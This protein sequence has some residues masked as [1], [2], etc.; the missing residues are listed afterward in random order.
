MS[1]QE[2]VIIIGGG[3]AGISSALSLAE[4][5]YQAYIIEKKGSIGGHAMQFCCKATKQCNNCGVCLVKDKI[6]KVVSHPNIHVLTHAEVVGLE[7]EAP[8]FQVEV[9]KRPGFIDETKCITCSLCYQNCPKAGD[10]IE[11]PYL[12]PVPGIFSIKKDQCLHF[13]KGKNCVICEEYC[14]TGAILFDQ[15]EDHLLIKGSAII[16][17]TGFESY[18]AREK[19]YLG[20]GKFSEVISGLDLEQSLM[21]Q[22]DRIIPSVASGEKSRIAFIQ[23]VGSRDPHIGHDYC[24]RVCCKYATRMGAKIK[25]RSGEVDLTIFYIDL[26]KTEREFLDM[27]EDL[28]EDMHF[29]KGLPV[30]IKK[31]KDS[32]VSMRYE[33]IDR[34]CLEKA[35]FDLVVLSVGICPD[36]GNR[37]LA[38]LLGI[39][40]AENGFFASP[41]LMDSTVS[42]RKGVFLA[43][44][45]HGPKNI[46]ESISHGQEAALRT[47]ALM[48]DPEGDR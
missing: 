37:S 19:G 5:G 28:S 27:I 41:D 30:E 39:N 36:L 33:N 38:E 44:T 2:Q 35:D 31:E 40:I 12:Y 18:D 29:V 13:Q 3:T 26:Q 45:C 4:N 34:G 25:S 15:Q 46:I 10:A 24:S 42:S 16:L 7:G 23:C 43:G 9:L 48:R 6:M 20:Y 8:D 22:A 32:G 11:R 1:E 17:A 47:V 14:P 21:M